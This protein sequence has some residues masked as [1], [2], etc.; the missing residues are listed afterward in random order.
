MSVFLGKCVMLPISVAYMSLCSY[1]SYGRPLLVT[2]VIEEK[3]SD[4]EETMKFLEL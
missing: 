1:I 3:V 2:V 4:R